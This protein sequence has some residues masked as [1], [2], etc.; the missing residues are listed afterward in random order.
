MAEAALAFSGMASFRSP[1]GYDIHSI[2]WS[3]AGEFLRLAAAEADVRWRDPGFRLALFIP[4][5]LVRGHRQK[6]ILWSWC[7]WRMRHLPQAWLPH[8]ILTNG[9]A[10]VVAVRKS[11]YWPRSRRPPRST[12][13]R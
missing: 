1:A 9:A 10:T 4:P 3:G 7:Y 13:L 12:G 5:L 8:G 6:R 11:R 2:T